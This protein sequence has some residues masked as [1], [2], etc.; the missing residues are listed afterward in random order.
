M[1]VAI[2]TNTHRLF[3]L[4]GG[5]QRSTFSLM[6][7]QSVLVLNRKPGEKVR[8]GTNVTVTVLE[9]QG[10]RVKIGIEAPAQLRV[11]H[12]VGCGW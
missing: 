5:G 7:E 6:E 11:L 4:P 9:V 2:R 10:N 3:R 8:I 12:C 1:T